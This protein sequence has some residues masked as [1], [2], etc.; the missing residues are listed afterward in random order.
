[1]TPNMNTIYDYLFPHDS[2]FNSIPKK[3]LSNSISD[4][5][6]KRKV[7]RS[8]IGS[9]IQLRYKGT[10]KKL[11]VQLERAKF[12]KNLNHLIALIGAF[13]YIMGISVFKKNG[14]QE[15]RSKLTSIMMGPSQA[16]QF[17][18]ILNVKPEDSILELFSGAGY[19]SF[20]LAIKQPRSLDCVDVRTSKI[21]NLSR[22]FNQ[23][24]KFVYKELPK[25]LQPQV[26]QPHFIHGDIA[27]LSDLIDSR[28]IADSYS[29]I[30]L[31]PPFGRNGTQILAN[32]AEAFVLWLTAL[33]HIVDN[34]KGNPDIYAVIPSEWLILTSDFLSGDLS[35]AGLQKEF[36][37]ILNIPYYR[38]RGIS[39]PRLKNIPK[40][41][42]QKKILVK[43]IQ[44]KK[45]AE[46]QLFDLSIAHIRL[47]NKRR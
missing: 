35:P 40:K 6:S 45:I 47:Y 4:L 12:K 20:F 10:A 18:Q 23:G 37:K 24:L 25:E 13:N 38:S 19:L 7:K 33:I 3:E 43:I 5:M 14:Q 27:N 30:V 11:R 26:T 22:T 9:L 15:I 32:E 36:S 41:I 29:K 2:K 21:Y 1:M 46:T 42:I 16:I 39:S 17:L 31:H 34:I 28:K 44:N 8:D